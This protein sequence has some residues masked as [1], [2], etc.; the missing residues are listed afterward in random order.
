MSSSIEKKK[1]VSNKKRRWESSTASRVAVI[2]GDGSFTSLA[3]QRYFVEKIETTHCHS[4]D[5]IFDAIEKDQVEYG[6]LPIENSDLGTIR[7]GV[8]KLIQREG[9]HI[10]GETYEREKHCLCALPGVEIEQL[11]K[12][13]SHAVALEQCSDYLKRIRST[14]SGSKIQLLLSADTTAACQDI[15]K[16]NSKTCAAIASAEA[17]KKHGLNVLVKDM[18]NDMNNETR[19]VVV[20]KTPISPCLSCNAKTSLVFAFDRDEPGL[21]FKALS[22]FSLR[23][24]S[25]LQ[26]GMRP[27]ARASH[28]MNMKPHWEYIT[29]IDIEGTTKEQKVL[30]AINHLKELTSALRVLGSYERGVNRHLEAK[31]RLKRS[32]SALLGGSVGGM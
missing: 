22:C 23:D 25:V 26:L 16:N 30:N 21:L 12:I 17:A 28:L 9:I 14:E 3:A 1:N 31:K 15:Q 27:A 8:D 7:S 19:F 13:T 2:G 29:Y 4:F 24:I 11:E 32:G 5:S 10:V 6:V 20:S 18:T